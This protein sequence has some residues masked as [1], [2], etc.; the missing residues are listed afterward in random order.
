MS[1]PPVDPSERLLSSNATDFE[2]RLLEAALQKRPSPAA[3]ARMARALGVSVAA[4][5]T[6][7]ATTSLA[8][9]AAASKVTAAAATVTWPWISIGVIGLVVAGAVVGT[10]AGHRDRT[11]DAEHHLQLAS[12]PATATPPSAP[13]PSVTAEP[14]AVASRSSPHIVAPS[15]HSRAAATAGELGEQI[16]FVDSARAAMSSGASRR[17]LEILRRYQDKYPTG[18]FRPEATAIKV[19]ALMKLGREAEGRAL[20]E[21]F[22]AEHRGTLLARRVADVAGVS[23]P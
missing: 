17:A 4:A 20:A 16:A 23:V 12:A 9:G 7:A 1:R 8:A 3:S 11:R 2:R 15:P 19:E 5:G 6:A 18:S 21:R 10:R 13:D 14:T 22:L